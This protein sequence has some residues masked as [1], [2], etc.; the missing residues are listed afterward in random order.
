V[1]NAVTRF[2]VP[3]QGLDVSG[4]GKNDQRVPTANGMRGPQN[5]RVEIVWP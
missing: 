2:G 1:A 4:G 3:Q 5:C